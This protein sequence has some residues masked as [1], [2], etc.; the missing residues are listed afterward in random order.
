MSIELPEPA[1]GT[2]VT[3]GKKVFLR[4]ITATHGQEM[5]WWRTGDDEPWDWAMVCST[6]APVRLVLE[7]PAEAGAR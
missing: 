1:S 5:S 4:Q 6:G 7:S 3:T 2:V